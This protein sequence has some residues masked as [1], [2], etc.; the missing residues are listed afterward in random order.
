VNAN[1]LIRAQGVQVYLQTHAWQEPMAIPAVV[2]M[3]RAKL[4]ATRKPGD[5]HP[6]VDAGKPGTRGRSADGDAQKARRKRA[7]SGKVRPALLTQL[8]SSLGS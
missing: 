4:L 7:E 6:F 5:L 8:L 3:S 1:R 2:S